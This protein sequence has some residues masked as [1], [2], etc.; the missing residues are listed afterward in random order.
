MEIYSH[1]VELE[2]FR[3][4]TYDACYVYEPGGDAGCKHIAFFIQKDV[5]A[6]IELEDLLDSR[7]LA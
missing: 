5:V 4:D 6:R 3:S 7:L 1:A 2:G